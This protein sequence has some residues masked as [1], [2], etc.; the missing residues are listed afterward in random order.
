MAAVHEEV[1][2]GRLGAEE[3][4]RMQVDVVRHGVVD[5]AAASAILARV[6]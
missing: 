3:L 4:V 6:E 1:V 2:G 5:P